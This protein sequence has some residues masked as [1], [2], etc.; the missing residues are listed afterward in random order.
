VSQDVLES[1]LVALSAGQAEALA[2]DLFGVR[3]RASPLTSE[4]DQNFRLTAGDG[5]QY[6][7]KISNPAEDAAIAEMQT[8]ALRHVASRDDG[9]PTPRVIPTT[10]GELAA[11]YAGPSGHQIV[12]L[13]TFLPGVLL[14]QAPPSAAQ[15]RSLGAAHARL[16]RALEGFSHP[17]QDYVLLWDL[18]Q[19]ASLLRLL[20]HVVEPARRRQCERALDAFDARVAPRLG[21]LRSQVVHNDL[22]PH[23]VVVDPADPDRVSGILDFGDMVR[24]PLVCDVAIAASY[25]LGGAGLDG[26]CD[27]LA[28]FHAILPLTAEELSVLYD[29]VAMRMAMSVLIS[30]WRASLHPENADYI[31]RNHPSAARGLARLAELGREAFD[32]AVGRALEASR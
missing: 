19:A 7:L 6:V 16:T 8:L 10:S 22:N 13:L 5:A 32:Q 20:P 11:T 4:R 18:K 2:A 23:N 24:T 25:Q 21:S 15:R 12:R 27:Y 17:A 14:H 30:E 29:L 28:A 31:L 26:L 3:G 1:P 9:A